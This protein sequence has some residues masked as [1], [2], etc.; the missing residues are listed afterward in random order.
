MTRV[1]LFGLLLLYVGGLVVIIFISHS[2]WILS[3]TAFFITWFTLLL[4]PGVFDG[5]N[6]ETKISVDLL[7]RLRVATRLMLPILGI[8]FIVSLVAVFS[9]PGVCVT[10]NLPLVAHRERYVLVSHGTHTEVSAL[11]YY[12]AG[13]G[14]LFGWNSIAL[15]ATVEALGR[16]FQKQIYRREG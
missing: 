4:K 16:S 1:F 11:R 3:M 15:V 8:L 13:F 2:G 10:D 14:F 6:G 5:R 7:R 9:Q 12:I